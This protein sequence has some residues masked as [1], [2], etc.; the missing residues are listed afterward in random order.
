MA[1]GSIDKDEPLIQLIHQ[2]QEQNSRYLIELNQ[3]AYT[4]NY[5]RNLLASIIQD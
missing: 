5:V 1:S 4:H 2:I 3:Q